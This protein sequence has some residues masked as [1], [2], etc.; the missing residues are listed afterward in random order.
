ML[1]PVQRSGATGKLPRRE[2]NPRF[3]E[4]SRRIG[5]RLIATDR[6]GY[7]LSDRLADRTY[8]DW[9]E[10]VTGTDVL[11]RGIWGPGENDLYCV[12]DATP[13]GAVQARLAGADSRLGAIS[14]QWQIGR[15][16][17]RQR[18]EIS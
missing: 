1:S 15:G 16:S 18:A 7:G 4:I 9:A 3:D 17:C 5:I 11:L 13:G 12:G 8:L 2:R 6:P 10:D 14:Y